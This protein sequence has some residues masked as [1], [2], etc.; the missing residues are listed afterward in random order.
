MKSNRDSSGAVQ[1]TNA[2]NAFITV[3][4][5]TKQMTP[6]CVSESGHLTLGEC[7]DQTIREA[8][9]RGDTIQALHLEIEPTTWEEMQTRH[10]E[11]RA[12]SLNVRFSDPTNVSHD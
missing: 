10:R 2:P 1:I 9:V 12:F 3:D 8:L 11:G 4:V 6:L 5:I 7:I